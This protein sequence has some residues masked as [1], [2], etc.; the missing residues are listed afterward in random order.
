MSL[1][2]VHITSAFSNIAQSEKPTHPPK[3]KRNRKVVVIR[4]KETGGEMGKGRG[5]NYGG[6][7]K[8]EGG[9]FLLVK[10]V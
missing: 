6:G 7:T 3:K 1:A 10:L 9:F 8:G 5:R 2:Q 4:R